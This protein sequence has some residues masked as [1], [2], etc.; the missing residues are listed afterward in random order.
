MPEGL[1]FAELI[2]RVGIHFNGVIQGESNVGTTRCAQFP[3]LER[4]QG[5]GGG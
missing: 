4:S 3:F 2:R 5:D 1:T